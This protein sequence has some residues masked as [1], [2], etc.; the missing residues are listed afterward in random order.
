MKRIALIIAAGVIVMGA[1]LALWRTHIYP[2]SVP[3]EQKVERGY[4]RLAYE[5]ALDAAASSSSEENLA[6]LLRVLALRGN[7]GRALV[8]SRLYGVSEPTADAVRSFQKSVIDEAGRTGTVENH[9]TAGELNDLKRFPVYGDLKFFVGYQ[10]ALL[11]DWNAG[12]DY[13]AEALRDGV[14]PELLPYLRYYY[15]RAQIIRGDE[16]ERK[17]GIRMLSSLL[18]PTDPYRLNARILLN[19]LDL[20]VESEELDRCQQLLHQIEGLHSRWEYVKALNDLGTAYEREHQPDKALPLFAQ[21]LLEKSVHGSENAAISGMWIALT[22]EGGATPESLAPSYMPEAIYRLTELIAGTNRIVDAKRVLERI[23]ENPDCAVEAR[24]AALAGIARLGVEAPFPPDYRELIKRVE[25]LSPGGKWTQLVHLNHARRLDAEGKRSEAERRYE[26]TARLEGPYSGDALLE[27]Y[28]LL[29]DGG[30]PSRIPQMISIL[31]QL[32]ADTREEHFLEA[33]EE[34]IPLY[35]CRGEHKLARALIDKVRPVDDAVAAYWQR[36][37]GGQKKAGKGGL[38]ASRSDAEIKHFSYYELASG[39]ALTTANIAGAGGAAALQLEESVSEYLLGIF[40]PDLALSVADAEGYPELTPMAAAIAIHNLETASSLRSSSWYA[41]ELLE[42]G[43]VQS[44]PVLPYLLEA[45]YPRPY[46]DTVLAAARRYRVEP[47]LIYAVMKKESNF[48]QDAVSP[49]GAVGLMQLMPSTAKLLESR[50]P[51]ELESAPL[52]DARKSIHL[53]AAY[54]ASLRDALGADYLVLAAYNA[55]PGTLKAWRQQ[56][57]SAEPELFINLI[58]SAETESFVKKTLKYK[59]IYE[60][61]LS[62]GAE[63][64]VRVE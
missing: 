3:F 12:R 64:E 60:F 13:F 44:H 19:Q 39:N 15:A 47:A 35:I 32:T 21:A 6:R 7:V 8:L 49:S 51:P 58:P 25:S 40:A 11:G 17:R 29:K 57:D 16:D 2:R 9:F 43:R 63:G 61:L 27:H 34:L 54:L 10:L 48:R 62:D 30:G 56:V 55:G 38:A 45:A 14:S 4:L 18:R 23:T 33:A 52:T 46:P 36:F 59:K 53:G 28:R 20:A 37:L 22:Q 31:G 42:S 26:H 24:G 50:L 5:E 41:T 1:A